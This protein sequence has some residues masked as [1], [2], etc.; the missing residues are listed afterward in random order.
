M[1]H[2]G[3][4][5]TACKPRRIPSLPKAPTGIQGLDE[6]TGGGL[7]KGRPTLLCGSSGCGKTLLAMEFLVRGAVDCGEPG[8]FMSFEETPGE[9]ATN[10]AS[11]GHDL[12]ALV[13]QKNLVLEFVHIDRSELEDTGAYV[14]PSGVLLTGSARD[15]LEAQEKAQSLVR[16]QEIEGKNTE[17]EHKRQAMEA[18][19]AAL[20]AEFEV[21]QAEAA[22][23]TGQGQT[24]AEV[25]SN[26]RVQIARMRQAD[27]GATGKTSKHK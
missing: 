25:L 6:L 13:A 4:K 5:N 14:G 12:T 17:L 18:Q 23:M 26:N 22:R 20:R 11:L 7:P 1:K 19:I 3:A 9:L 15:V 2:N 21:E 27:A 16:V 8:V 10:F 24:R